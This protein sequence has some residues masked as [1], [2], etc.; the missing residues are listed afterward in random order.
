M[1]KSQAAFSSCIMGRRS[2]SSS[3]VFS[4]RRL[5][6]L[7]L[8]P[9]LAAPARADDAKKAEPGLTFKVPFT[10][11]E[12]KHVLIRAK[13]NGKG[14]YNFIMDTGAP[15]LFV[16]TAVAKKLGVEAGKD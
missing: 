6:V 11:T 10:Q 7:L 16:S 12:T 1:A 14:P 3:G 8:L 9:V 13:I 5:L 4:M 2:Y 15:A